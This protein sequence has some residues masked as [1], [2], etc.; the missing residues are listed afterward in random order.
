[1]P[2]IINSQEGE[3]DVIVDLGLSAIEITKDNRNPQGAAWLIF[4][5]VDGNLYLEVEVKT[6]L[7]SFLGSDGGSGLWGRHVLLIL[8]RSLWSSFYMGRPLD[9]GQFVQKRHRG[10][11]IVE[12]QA[13]R[14]L[15]DEGCNL[16]SEKTIL[17]EVSEEGVCM[18]L[19]LTRNTSRPSFHRSTISWSNIAEVRSPYPG[20]W[21]YMIL[22]FVFTL[23][24]SVCSQKGHFLGF[25]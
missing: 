17:V 15:D 9:V 12:L 3:G 10:Q 6:K 11:R 2:R 20:C 22:R 21:S 24:A 4:L 13:L 1:M 18:V 19:A 14:C 16:G 7:Q 8:S 23:E 25:P 5:T